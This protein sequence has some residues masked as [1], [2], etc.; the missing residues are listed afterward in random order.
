MIEDAADRLGGMLMETAE[1]RAEHS[2]EDLAAAVLDAGLRA[3]C[4]RRPSAARTEAVAAAIHGKLHRTESPGWT[5]LS[6]PEKSFWFDMARVAIAA[7]DGALR[8]E[9][10]SAGGDESG[11]R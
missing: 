3:A 8:D 1:G 10:N 7:S 9:L 6:E 11:K 5:G 2:Y 4:E